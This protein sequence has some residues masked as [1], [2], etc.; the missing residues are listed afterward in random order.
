MR[1]NGIW[2]GWGLGDHSTSDL[3]VQRFK[4]YARNMFRGYAG[5]LADTNVFDAEL[6]DVVIEM[7]RRLVERPMNEHRL[8]PGQFIR[9]VLDMP[10]QLACGFRKPTTPAP[11]GIVVAPRKPIIFTIEGH[12]SDP[13]IGPCAFTAMAL[14]REGLCYHKPIGYDRWRM[15]FNNESGWLELA[16]QLGRTTI[17]GPPG[18]LWPFPA[19]TPWGIIDFSQGNIIG[20]EFLMRYVIRGDL[21]WRYQDLKRSLS[22]G[23][24]Y[25]ELDQCADWVPDPPR[26][27]TQGISDVRFNATQILLTNG[28]PFSAI[29][30]EVSR[31]GDIY[32]ENETDEVGLN[33]TMIYK[34]VANGSFLNFGP[35]G[36]LMRVMDLIQNPTDGI[37]DATR[38]I[39]SGGMFLFNMGPHGQY[40][41]HPCIEWMRGVAA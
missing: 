27:G 34:M 10:T 40:D 21:N 28:Q 20:R 14:E 38:S 11:N 4:A 36:A 31:R 39:I 7:Q 32:A 16:N 5:H 37:F 41:L 26:D 24:P 6:F 1:I 12:R 23:A 25:R 33:K 8:V 18:T 29:H 9:G 30:R 19:G 15:P 35:A 22:F 3:T 13:L 17:E 2:V